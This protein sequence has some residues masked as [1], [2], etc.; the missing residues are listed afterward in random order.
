M[1]ISRRHTFDWR[2][3]SSLIVTGWHRCHSGRTW[4][5]LWCCM[6]ESVWCRCTHAFVLP[7]CLGIP[8]YAILAWMAAVHLIFPNHSRV[9][10]HHS[11]H[12][13]MP[14]NSIRCFFCSRTSALGFLMWYCVSSVVVCK[15]PSLAILAIFKTRCMSDCSSCTQP[16]CIAIVADILKTYKIILTASTYQIWLLPLPDTLL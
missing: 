14:K 16:P 1:N 4:R 15:N 8:H 9:S 12:M 6:A 10:F 11:L 7:V 2:S 13:S 5:Q 3:V